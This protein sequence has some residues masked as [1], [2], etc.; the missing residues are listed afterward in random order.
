MFDWKGF[1][2]IL[3][4][5]AMLLTERHGR[6]LRRRKGNVFEENL[7]S[8]TPIYPVSHLLLLGSLKL[9]LVT[10]VNVAMCVVLLWKRKQGQNLAGR[11]QKSWPY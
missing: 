11:P 7:E 4:P 1:L 8:C 9:N 6:S 10:K 3:V 5:L 2:L